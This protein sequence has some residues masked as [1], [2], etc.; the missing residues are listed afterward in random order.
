MTLTLQP[1]LPVGEWI[2]QTPLETSETGRLIGRGLRGG[3]IILLD[4]SLGAGKTTFAKGLAAE[5][6]LDPDEITS[7]SFSLVNRHTGRLLL[8]HLDLYRLGEGA[9]AA[10]AVD[11]DEILEDQR[12]VTVIEWA[13]RLGNYP[14]PP[15]VWRVTIAGDGDEAR[16]ILVVRLI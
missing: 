1:H 13:I 10:A 16:R 4:G 9:A 15:P 5:L 2:C 14:L 6:A 8:Y 3:E 11:L 12:A 7:P